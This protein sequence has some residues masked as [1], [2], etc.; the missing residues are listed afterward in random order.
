MVENPAESLDR[1]MKAFCYPSKVFEV[2][3]PLATTRIPPPEVRMNA[4]TVSVLFDRAHDFR[5]RLND[6]V[7]SPPAF[8]DLW[9]GANEPIEQYRFMRV[10]LELSPESF[11]MRK[12]LM[13]SFPFSRTSTSLSWVR[14]EINQQQDRAGHT[15]LSEIL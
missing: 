2:I 10:F 11:E 14:F 1:G 7:G 12:R 3:E 6:P 9:I 4:A 15:D 13:R 8:L 5:A